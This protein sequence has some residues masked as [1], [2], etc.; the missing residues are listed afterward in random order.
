MSLKPIVLQVPEGKKTGDSI[1]PFLAGGDAH[2]T[3]TAKVPEGVQVKDSFGVLVD[4]SKADGEQEAQPT[5][6]VGG[7]PVLD[8]ESC[9]TL[10]V[11]EG[12]KAGHTAGPFLTPSN[13]EFVVEVPKGKRAGDTMTCLVEGGS[14][15]QPECLKLSVP[16]DGKRGD[17]IGPFCC[18]DKEFTAVVPSYA[19]AGDS[20]HVYTP[21][22][23]GGVAKC[24]QRVPAHAL[25]KGESVLQLRIPPG[26]KEGDQF[27]GV[28]TEDGKEI[29]ATVPKG[30][31]GGDEASFEIRG[32]PQKPKAA[33]SFKPPQR[34][35]PSKPDVEAAAPPKAPPG[36]GAVPTTAAVGGKAPAPSGDADP[37]GSWAQTAL[38]K[39][40]ELRAKHGAPPL[41]WDQECY[42]NAK[43][44]A[45]YC[46]HCVGGLE[47]GHQ[48]GA[49]GRH[50]QNAFWSSVPKG[51]DAAA[52]DWYSEIK[53]Y[54]W[55]RP[56]YNQV[57]GIV[58]HFTQNVWVHSRRVGF[59]RS[60][61]GTFIFANFFPAGN[62]MGKF[63]NNVL[64]T[65]S[66]MQSVSPLPPP[67]PLDQLQPKLGQTVY[68]PASDSD[69]DRAMAKIPRDEE[70]G[71]DHDVVKYIKQ[72]KQNPNL[73]KIVVQRGQNMIQA[74]VYERSG[75]MSMQSGCWM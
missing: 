67:S 37:S 60:D 42:N 40:N 47:H 73:A 29:V 18:G 49:S 4:T 55:S 63:P 2:C 53:N 65:G 45:N 8:S 68:P 30:K 50:G 75:A 33:S 54:D 69:L 3:F 6:T 14:K 9:L 16:E 41:T 36:T 51:P 58:G 22:A 23:S 21:D 13:E 46:Q 59:A 66:P 7:I 27:R 24:C 71:E 44:Q 72:G 19:K 11:P 57:K 28:F 70:S 35:T 32:P 64:P 10:T 52:E 34:V 74:S 31:K 5:E 12:K 1:G 56:G 25:G 43:A 20:F 62:M 39:I 61:D 48:Q 26:K 38:A 15:K 17:T